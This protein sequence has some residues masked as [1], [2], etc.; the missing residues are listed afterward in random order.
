MRKYQY[1]ERPN[2]YKKDKCRSYVDLICSKYDFVVVS[3][4]IP[5]SFI[6]YINYC[7][8]KLILEVTNR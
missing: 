2:C 5:D 1:A 8:A 6:Y 3:D 7:K 4:I